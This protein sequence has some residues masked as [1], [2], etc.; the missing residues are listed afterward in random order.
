MGKIG[1]RLYLATII[2]VFL[3]GCTAKPEIVER[4]CSNCH[5]SSVVYAKKRTAVEWRGVVH[6]M[7]V[8]GLKV[9][10]E[11]E[12]AILEALMEDYGK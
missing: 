7:K 11:E 6:G 2:V 9:T 10:P 4:K 3:V 8:R 5:A 1:S 12:T